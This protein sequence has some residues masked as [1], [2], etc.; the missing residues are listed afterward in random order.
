MG[1]LQYDILV[2]FSWIRI[3][4]MLLLRNE[5]FI[6]LYTGKTKQPLHR[7]KAQH[8]RDICSGRDSAVHLRLKEKGHSFEDTDVYDLAREERWR[9]TTE[10]STPI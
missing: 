2:D 3:N 1:I 8:R 7:R 5:E 9:P 6:D 10:R 4:V